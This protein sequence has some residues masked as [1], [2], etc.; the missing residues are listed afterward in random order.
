MEEGGRIQGTR[1]AIED[2]II[3]GLRARED[4]Y[5]QSFGMCDSLKWPGAGAGSLNGGSGG[6]GAGLEEDEPSVLEKKRKRTSMQGDNMLG[7]KRPKLV[8][9][10][11]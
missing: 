11:V 9:L 8:L 3:I 2:I 10:R 5:G 7:E 4:F 1:A 6:W